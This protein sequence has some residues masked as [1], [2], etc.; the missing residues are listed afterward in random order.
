[1]QKYFKY[2][3]FSIVFAFI[4]INFAF[5]N[6]FGDF[7][8]DFAK[9]ENDVFS[10]AKSM[11]VIEKNS[12]R[13]LYSKNENERLPMASLTKIIT[14]F[15]VLEHCKNIDEIVEIQKNSVGIEGT[16]IGLKEGEH[17]SVREL[18]YGL[19][20]RSGND[21]AVA[22][23][24][25]ISG[26]VEAF[27]EEVNLWLIDLGF[28]NT[29][30]KNPHGLHHDEHYTTAY[31]LAKITALALDN[32]LF[33][34]IVSTKEKEISNE[35]QTKTSRKL[36]NKN[37]FL[38]E[39]EFANGVKTGFTRKAGRCF[40]GSAT[41][42]DMQVICVLLNCVPMFEECEAFIDKAFSEYKQTEIL[43]KEECLGVVNVL[44][45]KEESVNVRLNKDFYYPLK[46]GEFN[47]I[48]A[49]FKQKDDLIAPLK[50]GEEL[51]AIE[52][53]FQNQLIFSDK[54]YTINYIKEKTIISEFK[55]IVNNM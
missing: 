17:L 30:I 32:S 40:V 33:Q 10:T 2:R 6:L 21:S 1:M 34:E 19:M 49:Q 43:S 23:A 45:A 35:L 14:A 42:N 24:T 9:C 50:E 51:G 48:K 46:E 55:K 41:K 52:I 8:C 13:I 29:Q 39:Y 25:K 26:S 5:F 18:L 20:L 44:N 38:K 7:L 37:R 47:F 4:L 15:F 22:L 54:I 12:G 11:V 27:I 16:S 28:K 31:E 53:S 3:R 36:K